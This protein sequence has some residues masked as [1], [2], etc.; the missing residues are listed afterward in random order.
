MAMVL[1]L[2]GMVLFC[3]CFATSTTM[4]APPM[5]T[6]TGDIPTAA[7]LP[8]INSYEQPV[9][10]FVTQSLETCLKDRKVFKFVSK[11][12]VD[13]AVQASG[14]N[15]D[16]IFGLSA[17]KYAALAKTLGV[18]YVIHGAM[19]VKKTLQFTGW[20]KDIDLSTRIYDGKTGK[21]VDSWRSMTDFSWTKGGTEL[22]AQKMA[23]SAAN[24]TCSK[25]MQRNY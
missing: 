19:T 22:D 10:D 12:E 7:M 2:A 21:K 4:T 14:F 15:L 24:H 1:A 8:I 6:R 17:S 23:T 20:R 9:A 3:G 16:K 18:D 13:K 5:A 25:M 11:T